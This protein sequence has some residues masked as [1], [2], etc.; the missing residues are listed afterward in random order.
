MTLEDQLAA[1]AEHGVALSGDV[2]VDDLLVSFPREEYEAQPFE[3]IL[4]MLGIESERE[5]GGRWIS[6]RAWNLDMECIAGT[7]DYV[8]IA[9]CLCR[10]AGQPDRLTDV[11]DTVDLDAGVASLSYS[12]NG[13]HRHH[14]VVVFG[15]WADPEVVARVMADIE[16]DGFRFYAVDNGQSSVWYYLD[17]ETA[18]RLNGLSGGAFVLGP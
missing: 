14:S 16:R 17:P 1:L 2:G 11:E 13:H 18:A 5:P 15:D 10:I 4:Y 8:H 12:V 3:L 6:P 7:G 9:R